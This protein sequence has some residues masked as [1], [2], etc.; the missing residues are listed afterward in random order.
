MNTLKSLTVADLLRE[1]AEIID[2]DICRFPNFAIELAGRPGGAREYQRR[3][4]SWNPCLDP[5]GDPR[6]EPAAF[7][8][9]RVGAHRLFAEYFK[10]RNKCD[11][12]EWFKDSTAREQCALALLFTAEIAESEA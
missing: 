9:I 7:R 5:K 4:A 1:A 11:G 12:E 10:P 6:I 3:W 8:L 2:A